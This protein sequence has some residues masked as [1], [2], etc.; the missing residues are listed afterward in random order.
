MSNFSVMLF[1]YVHLVELWCIVEHFVENMTSATYRYV[2][3]PECFSCHLNLRN[4]YFFV[5]RFV[6]SNIAV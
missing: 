6:S 5:M 1:G 2:G 3:L 4:I